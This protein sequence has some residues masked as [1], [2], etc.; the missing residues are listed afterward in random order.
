MTLRKP[1]TEHLVYGLF[2]LSVV[3]LLFS[4]VLVSLRQSSDVGHAK[5][6]ETKV[7][8]A[9]LTKNYTVRYPVFSQP[10]VD[11]IIRSYVE[12]KVRDFEQRSSNKKDIR[13]YLETNFR[14]THLGFHT[15]SITFISQERVVGRPD[16][17]TTER[18]VF[19]VEEDRLLTF[20][21]IV[22]SP[23]GEVALAHLLH[24][25]FK[26]QSNLALTPAELVTLLEILPANIQEFALEDNGLMIFIN[27]R[28]PNNHEGRVGVRINKTLLSDILLESYCTTDPEKSETAKNIAAYH[29]TAQPQAGDTINPAGKMIA[30]TFDDGP[31]HLTSQLLDTLHKYEAKATFFVLGRM[32]AS[33]AAILQRMVSEGSEIGNHSWGHPILPLVSEAELQ[34]QVDATQHVIQAVTG[35]YAPKLIRPPYGATSALVHQTLAPRGLHEVLWSVDTNDWRDR[36]SQLIYDRIMTGAADGG[37]I[38]LH[39]IHPTSVDAAVWAIRDLKAQGYQLVT[40]SQLYQHRR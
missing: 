23:S 2:L 31:S 12:K 22:Q 13:N 36:D 16:V 40:V 35:G 30:L 32:V 17:T 10:N 29:I 4:F 34:Y 20:R 26:G 37:V 24:N 5:R 28:Q 27:P 3:F 39:D 1:S 15:A 8:E 18:F 19:D 25:Y 9:T 14:V 21:D 33:H 38:L 7:N 6:F 11:D